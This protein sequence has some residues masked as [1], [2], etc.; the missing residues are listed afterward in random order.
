MLFQLGVN[1]FCEEIATNLF[2]ILNYRGINLIVAYNLVMSTEKGLKGEKVA[3]KYLISLGYQILAQNY[4]SYFGEVDL[5]CQ[6]GET[7]V[8]V[9]VKNYKKDSIKT[10]YQAVSNSKRHKII[11]TAQ[12]YIMEHRLD[13]VAVQFD[14]LIIESGNVI[15]HLE[16]AFILD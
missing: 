2:F 11:K 12:R 6:K 14:V 7:I 1:L 15:D 16:G 8:F 10:P 9:E 4:H 5:V 3:E 13:N